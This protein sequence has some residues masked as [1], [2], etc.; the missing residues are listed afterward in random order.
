MPDIYLEDNNGGD[1]LEIIDQGNDIYTFQSGH[2]CVFNIRKTGT[3]SDIT[4]WLRDI[5]I[6]SSAESVE[7]E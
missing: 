2:Q 6:S 7:K 1:I 5:V 3:I 4:K